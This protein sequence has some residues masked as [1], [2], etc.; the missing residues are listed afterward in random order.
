MF[1]NILIATDGSE[2]ASKAVQDGIALARESGAKVTAV[3]VF[4]PFHTFSMQP[5]IVEDTPEQYRKHLEAQSA[6]ALSAVTQAATAAGVPCETI[7]EENDRPYQAII[8]IARLK[9]CDLV[10]MAS[11]RRHGLDSMFHGS[12]TYKV[13]THSDIPVLVS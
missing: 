12:E 8:D 4:P 9:G 1:T 13:L 10:V 2:L 6:K 3:T 7:V 5:E 11:H